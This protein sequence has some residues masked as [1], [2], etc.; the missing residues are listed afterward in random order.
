MR[1]KKG[2]CLTILFGLTLL[3]FVMVNLG[4]PGSALS[5][6]NQETLQPSAPTKVKKLTPDDLALYIHENGTSDIHVRNAN[7]GYQYALL[8]SNGKTLSGWEDPKEGR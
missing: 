5:A 4:L 2:K 7:Q 8:D 3:V 6:A 1:K